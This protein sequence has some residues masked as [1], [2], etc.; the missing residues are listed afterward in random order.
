MNIQKIFFVIF[1]GGVFLLIGPPFLVPSRAEEPPEKVVVI[2]LFHD[3]SPATSYLSVPFTAFVGP[4][5]GLGALLNAGACW[6]N[7]GTIL[8][9]LQAPVIL[10]HGAV[11]KGITVNYYIY[12]GGDSRTVQLL[13][14]NKDGASATMAQVDC[15]DQQ[16][17]HASTTTVANSAIDNENYTY[18]LY[19]FGFNCDRKHAIRW[20]GIKYEK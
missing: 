8:V 12:Y 19:A 15:G 17:G 11:V 18:F 4:Y 1:L 2:P 6:V 10:P 14:M 9:W 3:Q 20:V 16:A 7:N 5:G 13:R